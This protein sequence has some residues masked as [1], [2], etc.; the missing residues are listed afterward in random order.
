MKKLL[1]LPVGEVK[2]G[3]DKGLQLTDGTIKKGQSYNLPPVADGKTEGVTA[4][5]TSITLVMADK[6]M[7]MVRLEDKTEQGWQFGYNVIGAQ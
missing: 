5:V 7:F 6:V 4:K 3:S 1:V 2:S